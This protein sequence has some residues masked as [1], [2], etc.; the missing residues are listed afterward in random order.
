M[1]SKIYKQNGKNLVFS[2]FECILCEVVDKMLGSGTFLY[3]LYNQASV[4]ASRY[5]I[6]CI[7]F[8]LNSNRDRQYMN[9]TSVVI[10]LNVTKY[11]CSLIKHCWEL[12]VTL[13]IYIYIYCNVS[14]MFLECFC[15]NENA[16]AYSCNVLQCFTMFPNVPKCF[17]MFQKPRSMMQSMRIIY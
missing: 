17:Q 1:N 16:L 11:Q 15:S 3:L 12:P 8:L 6:F 14:V 13:Y 9:W 10:K 5:T 2:N 4:T 7:P